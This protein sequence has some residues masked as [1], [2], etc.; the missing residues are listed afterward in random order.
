MDD[1]QFLVIIYNE[2]DFFKNKHQLDLYLY[3][4]IGFVHL[5]CLK[6]SFKC[7]WIVW[8]GHKFKIKYICNIEYWCLDKLK[9]LSSRQDKKFF[10]LLVWRV[11][12]DSYLEHWAVKQFC[13]LPVTERVDVILF[14]VGLGISGRSPRQMKRVE[15]LTFSKQPTKQEGVFSWMPT[16][17]LSTVR[18]M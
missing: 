18:A 5:F 13:T 14:R 12:L 1:W 15:V 8:Y 3:A 11:A 10:G 9:Y 2:K 4:C 6:K 7:I 17:R 16:T